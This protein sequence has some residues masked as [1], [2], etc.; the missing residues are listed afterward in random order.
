MIYRFKTYFLILITFSAIITICCDVSRACTL[1]AAAGEKVRGQGT[2]LAKNR[3][4]KPE[5]SELRLI[6]PDK[7]FKYLGIFPVEGSGFQGLVAGVNEKGLAIVSAT[8]GSISKTKRNKGTKGLNERILASFES[9]DSVTAD[10]AML[11]K[12]HP[13]FY[14]VADKNKAAVI[15]VATDGKT[16]VKTVENGILFHTNHYLDELLTNANEKIGTSSLKRLDRIGYLL[17]NHSEQFS[18][19][20][21]IL[22]GSDTAEGPDNSIWRT[23]GSPKKERTLATWIVLIPKQGNPELYIKFANP[24]QPEFELDMKLDTSFWTEGLE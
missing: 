3:D 12:S 16:A 18:M 1:W 22:F 8:A 19:E 7:G 11:K 9:V 24:G 20:D 15:E 10:T 13:V 14:M 6:I 5:K 4:Y 2:I 17:K 23:G 21:F